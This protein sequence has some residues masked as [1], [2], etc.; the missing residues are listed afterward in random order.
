MTEPTV[1]G[2]PRDAVVEIKDLRFQ[3]SRDADG[4][5]ALDAFVLASGERAALTGPSGVGKSTLLNL[6][7]G[8]VTPDAGALRV[9]GED[10][11]RLSASRR[12]R[13][14]ADRMGVIFQM[15]N[16]LPFASVR[17]NVLLPLSFSS[18]RRARASERSGAPSDEADR[19][20]SALGLDAAGI[21]GRAAADLSVGQQQRV[22]AARALI[23]GP[24]LIL[25][26]E[27]TAALDRANAD[28]FLELLFA[29]A[30]RAG[31]AV[32]TVTHDP[33]VAAKFDRRLDL[34]AAR[35]EADEGASACS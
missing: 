8:A 16:L 30:E 10:M 33:S 12:D 15:F 5:V 17:D 19:L 24:E 2:T 18:R 3:W 20:L 23:G 31:A 4:G 6:I 25:A 28:A 35:A 7:S 9:L 11:M 27:P 29:E 34:G 13:L 26:D 21:A 14:R 22:A 1:G 32:L